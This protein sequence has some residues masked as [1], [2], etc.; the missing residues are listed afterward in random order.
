MQTHQIHD[1]VA[2]QFQFGPQKLGTEISRNLHHAF[3]GIGAN[4]IQLFLRYQAVADTVCQR[5]LEEG[6]II[7]N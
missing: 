1:A 3:G 7:E 6:A 2:C 5:F 4:G